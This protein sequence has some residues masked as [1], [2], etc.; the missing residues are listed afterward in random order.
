MC[1]LYN[2]IF[3]LCSIPVINLG[4]DIHLR[5]AALPENPVKGKGIRGCSDGTI[6]KIFF[7]V[8]GKTAAITYN[9]N[10]SRATGYV[11][12]LLGFS[13]FFVVQT[14]YSQVQK[15]MQKMTLGDRI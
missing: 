15:I 1:W 5:P 11:R 4:G 8:Y 9:S 6:T 2:Y 13:G 3:F 10:N 7:L 14:F 12:N